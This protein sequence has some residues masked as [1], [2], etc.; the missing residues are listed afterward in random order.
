MVRLNIELPDEV[1]EDTKAA[2]ALQSQK[3]EEYVVSVLAE[4]SRK[5]LE[6]RLEDNQPAEEN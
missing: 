2:A 5:V 6:A 3:L 1:H 4:E